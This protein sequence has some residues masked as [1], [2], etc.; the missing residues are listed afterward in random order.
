MGTT[1]MN[2]PADGSA[3][4]IGHLSTNE[5]GI[6]QAALRFAEAGL[7]V[8]PFMRGFIKIGRSTRMGWQPAV[9]AGTPGS[10]D[11]AQLEAWFASNPDWEIGIALPEQIGMLKVSMPDE[12]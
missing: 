10:V 3:A 4:E 11:P 2:A 12:L 8:V 6:Y 5:Q 9:P 7:P 1:V